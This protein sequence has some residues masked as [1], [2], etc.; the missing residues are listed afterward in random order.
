MLA[1]GQT[2]WA[3][4]FDLK[5][6][7]REERRSTGTSIPPTLAKT[8]PGVSEKSKRELILIE[9]QIGLEAESGRRAVGRRFG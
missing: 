9:V 2:G 7:G 6:F 8:D 4:P 3:G 1:E 5:L